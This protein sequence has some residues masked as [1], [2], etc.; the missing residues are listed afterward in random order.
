[1]ISSNNL[2]PS[3]SAAT[4]MNSRKPKL[5][6]NVLG[7]AR[8]TC[9]DLPGEGFI[10]GIPSRLDRE[11]CKI[12]LHDWIQSKPSK[13]PASRQSFVET[14]KKALAEG[15]T[16]SK[17]QREYAKAHPVMKKNPKSIRE[18]MQLI[19]EHMASATFGMSSKNNEASLSNLLLS[20][21]QEHRMDEADYP[22]LSNMKQKGRLPRA[23]P[24]KSTKLLQASIVGPPPE[25]Q[26]QVE[27][28][29]N[30]KMKRFVANAESKIDMG[31]LS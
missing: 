24:T 31:R 6:K 25:L 23:K 19:P 26:Q 8:T 16:T 13:P 29:N 9:Y 7:Q 30:W 3:T 11:G 21:S 2:M 15:Y 10:Y 12:I 4:P 22:D 18:D 5:V 20:S 28:K 17:K 27:Q 1:M 14:N